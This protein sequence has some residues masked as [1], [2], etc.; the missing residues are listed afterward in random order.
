MVLCEGARCCGR[1][2]DQLRG[3]VREAVTEREVLAI[4]SDEET[5][6]HENDEQRDAE[7]NNDQEKV[8]LFWW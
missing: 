4:E 2:E 8:R 1:G 5:S 7:Q 3:G 6:E